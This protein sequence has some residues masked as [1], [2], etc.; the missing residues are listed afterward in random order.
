MATINDVWF[1]TCLSL[2]EI[3]KR[4]GLRDIVFDCEDNWEWVTG[5]FGHV[6]LDV[7]R[8]H[9]VSRRMTVTRII[10][11]DNSLFT[12]NLL[13]ELIAQLEKFVPGKINCGRWEYRS[14]NEFDKCIVREIGK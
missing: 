8:T 9:T 2:T 3:A 4:L 13:L 12:E 7:T 6:R 11:V 1:R 14:G 5:D 10:L